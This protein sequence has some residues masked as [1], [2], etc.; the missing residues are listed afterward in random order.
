M[1][2]EGFRGWLMGTLCLLAPGVPSLCLCSLHT[3]LQAVIG[4]IVSPMVYP[5]ADSCSTQ[6]DQINRI[7]FFA[8]SI[9]SIKLEW[10]RLEGKLYHLSQLSRTSSVLSKG[11]SHQMVKWNTGNTGRELVLLVQIVSHLSGCDS[12]RPLSFGEREKSLQFFMEQVS[13]LF[14]WHFYHFGQGILAPP[15]ADYAIDIVT[16][17]SQRHYLGGRKR[18]RKERVQNPRVNSGDFIRLS[19]TME[20]MW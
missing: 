13:F 18:R 3:A 12:G 14:T 1:T 5:V 20:E 4:D 19:Q 15:Q 2:L 16:L 10:I 11:T 17:P 6:E 8:F 7:S 9:A